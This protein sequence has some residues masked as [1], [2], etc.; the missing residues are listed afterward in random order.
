MDK[1]PIKAK[2]VFYSVIYQKLKEIA[3]YYG[4]NLLIHGSLNRDLDLVAIPWIDD[5]VSEITLVRR[6]HKELCNVQYEELESKKGYEFSVLPGG[7]NNYIINLNRGGRFNNYLDEQWYLDISF[8]PLIKSN[9][10]N[11]TN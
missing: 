3:E 5:P 2:P 8:T 1:K 7:R 11:N 4:Y 6:F 9:D 10:T